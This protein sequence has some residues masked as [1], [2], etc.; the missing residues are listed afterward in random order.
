MYDP[1]IDTTKMFRQG[2]PKK[3]WLALVKVPKIVFHFEDTPESRA[4]LQRAYNCIFDLA[5]KEIIH[6]RQKKQKNEN[7]KNK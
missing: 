1:Y 4:S 2:G 3:S 5:R 6:K 7:N